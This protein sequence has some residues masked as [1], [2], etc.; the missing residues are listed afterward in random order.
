MAR[1]LLSSTGPSLATYLINNK[2]QMLKSHAPIVHFK[3][4]ATGMS[5]EFC[6]RHNCTSGDLLKGELIN[7]GE[8]ARLFFRNASLVRFID[9][10]WSLTNILYL[11]V[12]S[13]YQR[14]SSL[15]Q[16]ELSLGFLDLSSALT[17]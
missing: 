1:H 3:N 9:I 4:I 14:L 11:L 6:Y 16:V 15:S 17:F 10:L 2:E 7:N 5:M 13:K 12:I 8:T